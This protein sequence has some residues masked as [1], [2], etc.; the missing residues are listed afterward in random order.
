MTF[1]RDCAIE[2]FLPGA[3]HHALTAATDLFQQFVIAELSQQLSGARGFVVRRSFSSAAEFSSAGVAVAPSQ[4]L[5]GRVAPGYSRVRKLPSALF[6]T[7]PGQSPSGAS[8]K[9]FAPHFRQI[10]ITL[11]I[12]ESLAQLPICTP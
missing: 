7:H 5:G 4:R 8:E 3:K 1:K 6:S 11:I 10:L 12:V 2:T 9:I